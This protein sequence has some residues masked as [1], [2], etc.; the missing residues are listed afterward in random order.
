MLVGSQVA[1]PDIE[2][3]I[4]R[5]AWS[6]ALVAVVALVA[7]GTSG[8]TSIDEK[9]TAPNET[10]SGAGANARALYDQLPEAIRTKGEIVFVGDSHPPYRTV[11]ADSTSVTGLD[12]DVQQALS[13]ILGVPIRIEIT[14]GLP[15][16]LAGMLSGRY[17]AFNG[18][19][20]A[21]PERLE[22]FDGVQWL[23]S[24]TS[25]L[26]PQVGGT[27]AQSTND[28]C[29]TQTAGVIGSITE[30][31]VTK[32]SAWCVAQGRSPVEFVGLADTNATL[33]AVQSGR[34]GSAALTQAGA[35]DAAAA[36][37]NTWRSVD[38]TEEQGAF[39]DSLVLL[40]PKG[41]GLAPVI[42]SAFKL[43]FE[44]GQ[45]NELVDKWN[46]QDIAVTAPTLNPVSAE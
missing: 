35:V 18:P 22:K 13:E 3:G 45:Y 46:L 33:L 9:S 38:Q 39:T 29:G 5:I 34:A 1:V 19:V 36:Q 2:W 37:P 10:L 31:S 8:C 7:V 24:T 12:I 44:D 14:S 17:D 42:Y 4:M 40:T 6:K 28:L 43:M 25:Y 26:I 16:M 20:K 21:T 27:N 23:T 11:G 41:N 15:A 32:L 30:Q